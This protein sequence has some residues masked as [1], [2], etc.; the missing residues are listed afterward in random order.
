MPKFTVIT[1]TWNRSQHIIPTIKSVLGQ[2]FTDFEYLIVGDCCSDDTE[3]IVRPFLS[4]RVHW[5]STSERW[6]SQSGPNNVGIH[7][8]KGDYI[9]YIGHD[10]LW[11][12]EH[13]AWH[14]KTLSVKDGPDISVSACLNFG[15]PGANRDHLVGID[16]QARRTVGFFYVP[17]SIAHRRDVC[18]RIGLWKR[19]DETD[20]FVDVEFESRAQAFGMKFVPN[21]AL[22]AFKFTAGSR[23]L[24]YLD[25][26]SFEQ[27]DFAARMKLPGFPQELAEITA[28]CVKNGRST[29]TQPV[30]GDGLPKGEG[31]RRI[32]EM[33]GL[34]EDECVALKSEFHL[35]HHIGWRAQDWRG[36]RP[37]DFGFIFSGPNPAPRMLIPLTCEEPVSLELQLLHP[38]REVF[39]HLKFQLNGL[40]LSPKILQVSAKFGQSYARIRLLC[41]LRAVG[42]S[43]L[44]IFHPEW[45][46][47]S[48]EGP[49]GRGVAVG[50]TRLRVVPRKQPKRL[51]F[52]VSQAWHELLREITGLFP[53]AARR[54]KP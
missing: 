38:D 8:A 52:M 40:D 35:Q 14:L 41:E 12:P 2:T 32:R 27:V 33:K 18:D 10:D 53:V 9:A 48:V 15:S 24:S 31:A 7:A 4:E 29:A 21:G 16:P 45:A 17:T 5:L 50:S 46:M 13:L 51:I 6:K 34:L 42:P 1:A 47:T 49:G 28:E 26:D 54:E 20:R 3:E 25:V 30:F 22:T 43:V 37:N 36:H 44:R 19:P 39:H 11:G 23:Y